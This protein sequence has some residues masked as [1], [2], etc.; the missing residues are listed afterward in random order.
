MVNL[1]HA[2]CTALFISSLLLIAGCG[3][4]AGPP[5]GAPESVSSPQIELNPAEGNSPP[6]PADTPSPAGSPSDEKGE[7]K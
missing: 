1:R 6:A 4:P 5:P 2:A 3:E 7:A